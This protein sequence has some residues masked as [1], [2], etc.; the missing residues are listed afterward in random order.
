M[1]NFDSTF[2]LLLSW[3]EEAEALRDAAFELDVRANE[4]ETVL[5]GEDEDVEFD[6]GYGVNDETPATPASYSDG[7][8]GNYNQTSG[9]KAIIWGTAAPGG[10]KPSI[11]RIT[12]TTAAGDTVVWGN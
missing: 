1:D 9:E 6:M 5:F 8:A 10:G 12:V 3:R 7:T 4:L 2:E 11:S